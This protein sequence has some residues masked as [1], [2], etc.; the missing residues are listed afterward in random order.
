MFPKHHFYSKNQN[1]V[2]LTHTAATSGWNRGGSRYFEK[3]K[4]GGGHSMLPT[5]VDQDLR[6]QMV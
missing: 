3:K 6:F 5:K 4:K 1:L 2:I